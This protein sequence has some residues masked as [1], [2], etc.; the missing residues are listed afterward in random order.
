M[1]VSWDDAVA[2]ARWASKRLPTEAEWEFACRGGLEG[3]AYAWGDEF[4]PAGK[5][6][7]N[8]WQGHFPEI[9][10]DEDGFPR[11][12]PVKSFPHLEQLWCSRHDRQHGSSGTVVGPTA[13]PKPYDLR[14][15]RPLSSTTRSRHESSWEFAQTGYLYD[16]A[17]LR[18]GL[19]GQ[20]P[21]AG[22]ELRNPDEPYQPKRVTAVVRGRPV[23]LQLLHQLSP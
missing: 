12:S 23:Q 7:A 21:G 15:A 14:Y 3:K 2:Y 13:R 18:P 9:N 5:Y 22:E 20:Y 16:A 11:L 8:T 1:H 10:S 4:Q 17:A 6:Q 19:H